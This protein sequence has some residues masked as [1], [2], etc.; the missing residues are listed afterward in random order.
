VDNAFY[1][2]LDAFTLGGGGGGA[3]NL[4]IFP[5]PTLG[6]WGNG[7][8]ETGQI[9]VNS[10]REYSRQAGEIGVGWW[11][12]PRLEL[13]FSLGVTWATPNEG[14]HRTSTTV[15]ATLGLVLR[16]PRRYGA[17][18]ANEPRP[19]SPVEAPPPA[20]A[21]S[22]ATP[23]LPPAPV[24]PPVPTTDPASDEAPVSGA[25]G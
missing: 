10:T 18:P 9:Y 13:Q 3:F 19:P 16:A 15:A 5:E 1:W 14:S 2:S 22:P 12:S 7:S 4:E 21:V 23:L 8:F 24:E 6:I 11:T 25:P 20:G 17:P